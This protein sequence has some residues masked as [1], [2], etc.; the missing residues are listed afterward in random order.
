MFRKLK[1][2]F[3]RKQDVERVVQLFRDINNKIEKSKIESLI[4]DKKIVVFKK[5]KRIAGAF[6]FAILGF[7][8]LIF[9]RKLAVQKKIRGKGVGSFILRKIKKFSKRKKMQGFLLWARPNAVHF[10]RKNRLSR[11]GRFFWWKR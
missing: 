5:R 4:Q 11:L 2:K 1:M 10:Y 7:A 8:G 6:S 9:I 3:A